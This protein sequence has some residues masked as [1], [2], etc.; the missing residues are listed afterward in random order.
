MSESPTTPYRYRQEIKDYIRSCERLLSST[1][2]PPDASPLSL[3]ERQVV[4]YYLEEIKKN[5][6]ASQR[7]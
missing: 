3:D 4:E 6:L 7:R 5:L 1:A 2:F